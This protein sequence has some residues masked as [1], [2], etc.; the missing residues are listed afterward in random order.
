MVH[1]YFQCL[2]SYHLF[3]VQIFSQL[4]YF[5]KLKNNLEQ[6]GILP[7]YG[8]V[9]S[10]KQILQTPGGNNQ[11]VQNNKVLMIDPE[12]GEQ[13]YVDADRVEEAKT[14][15]GLQVVNE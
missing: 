4:I 5:L 13:D 15:D 3:N 9:G 1:L 11:I 14:V 6:Q 7:T 12:T 8:N 2:L 10:N